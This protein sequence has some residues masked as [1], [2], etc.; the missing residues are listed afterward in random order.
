MFKNVATK[1]ALYA[2][3]AATG[4]PKTGDAANL[5]FYLSKDWGS[6]TALGDTSATEMDATNAPGWYLC[7][8]TQ[9]ESNAD[10]LLFTAKSATA[11]VYVIGMR[12][13]TT[14]NRFTTLVIDAAGLADANTVKIGPTGS[15]TAQT[16]KDVGGAVPAAAAGASGGLL[17]S[18]SNAGTTTLGALT[19]TGA[20][21]LTGNVQLSDGLTIPAPSTGNRSGITVTGNGTGDGIR[22]TGGTSDGHGFYSIGGGFGN[23]FYS[24]GGPSG[25]I[26]MAVQGSVGEP[27]FAASAGIFS[28]GS[29][30]GSMTGSV[31]SVTAITASGGIVS[32]DTKKMNG[33]TV[34]GTG[35]SGDLWRG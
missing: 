35:T 17:I 31:A 4:V 26:G 20:T 7:D 15:G 32:A 19:V 29:I 2:Y 21:T 6:V 30:I 14:P 13:D 8:V 10:V 22:I 33:T 27:D 28:V 34:N 16:A 23:G 1:V 9:T 12:I 3:T 18:G 25:A 24:L 11:G 5:T